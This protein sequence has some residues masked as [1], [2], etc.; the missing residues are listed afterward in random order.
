[1]LGL[2]VG[3]LVATVM[4]LVDWS[5]VGRG[6]VFQL[7]Q[8]FASGWPRFSIGVIVSMTIVILV[9]MAETTADILA[10]GEI[11]GTPAPPKRIAAG[12]RADMAA[13]VVSR[14]ST[15]SRSARS[16]RTSAWSR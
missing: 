13:T 3:T 4:G 8:P 16:P 11:L 14:C 9:I 10:V 12:L 15:A 2:V 6:A 1:M 5:A 7:P